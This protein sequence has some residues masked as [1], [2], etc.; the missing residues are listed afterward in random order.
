MVNCNTV[1]TT[2]VTVNLG[3]NIFYICFLVIQNKME[4]MN[5]K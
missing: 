2:V 4:L 5:M 1:S 3:K